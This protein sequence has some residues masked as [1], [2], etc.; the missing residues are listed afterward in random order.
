VLRYVL[1]RSPVGTI[2]RMVLPARLAGGREAVR[3]VCDFSQLGVLGDLSYKGNVCR[4][5]RSCSCSTPL[6]NPK[7]T[8][9]RKSSR[10]NQKV[11]DTQRKSG[12]KNKSRKTSRKV[13]SHHTAA[14]TVAKEQMRGARRFTA[15]QFQEFRDAQVPATLR[16]LAERNVSQTRALY[17]RSKDAVQAVLVSWNRSFGAANQGAV[18]LNLKIMDI[19]E[20]NI[21]TGF[22]L[23]VNLAGA[24]NV[25]EA[26]EMQSAYWRKQLGQL[27]THAEEVRTLLSRL[28]INVTEPIETRMKRGRASSRRPLPGK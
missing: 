2:F 8:V 21:S 28:N 27:Q 16:D 3:R 14:L 1:M 5:E 12:S 9:M 19:A 6:R 10:K 17:Q 24:K 4:R 22:D 11:H 15:D 26:V 13:G 25:A 20:Q 18:A 23:A 7:R